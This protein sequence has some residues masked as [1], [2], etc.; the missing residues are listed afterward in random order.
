MKNG[1][2]T[3]LAHPDTNVVFNGYQIPYFDEVKDL[4][5]SAAEKIPA[6]RL[7]GW[8]IVLGEQGPLLLEGNHVY[9]IGMSEMAYGGYHKNPVFQKVL[10][11]AGIAQVGQVAR[12]FRLTQPQCAYDMTDAKLSTR[13]QIE[14]SQSGLVSQGLEQLHGFRHGG[15]LQSHVVIRITEYIVH[16]VTTATATKA[17]NAHLPPR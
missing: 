16:I 7:V 4:A 13:D 2:K 3:H 11:E 8:D 14:N 17:E 5:L 10:D 9:H 6:I 1:A 12:Y 15:L